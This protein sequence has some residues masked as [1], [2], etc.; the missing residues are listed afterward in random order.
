MIT[1]YYDLGYNMVL[2]SF[3]LAAVLIKVIAEIR[4]HCRFTGMKPGKKDELE[5]PNHWFPRLETPQE[6]S[7]GF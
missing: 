2:P 6:N 7:E 5:N 3:P 4:E 1:V